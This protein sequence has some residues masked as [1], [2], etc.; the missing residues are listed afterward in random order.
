MDILIYTHGKDAPSILEGVKNYFSQEFPDKVFEWKD[1]GTIL[2]T[3]SPQMSETEITGAFEE[4]V[5]KY[6]GLHVEASYSY[7][8]RE[9]DRSA[10]WWG[11]TRISSEREDGETSIVSSSSTYWN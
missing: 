10:Q 5:K 11:V 8:V 7:D 9:D 4:L 1:S 2:S 3:S 6:P